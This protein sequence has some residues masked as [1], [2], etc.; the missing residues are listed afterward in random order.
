MA[1]TPSAISSSDPP[2]PAGAGPKAVLLS[3]NF[4]T[5]GLVLRWAERR[6]RAA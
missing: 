6:R 4:S 1:D 3:I 5:R 2:S